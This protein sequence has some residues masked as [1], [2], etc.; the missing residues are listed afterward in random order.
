LVENVGTSL[1]P[2]LEPILLQ[3]V[4][5]I[6]GSKTIVLGDKN[7]PYSDSFKFFMTTTN[8]NPHYSPEI[9]AKVTIIN[10]GITPLGLEE[11]ML[12]LVVI[13]ESPEVEKKKADIVRTNAADKKK[14]QDIEDVI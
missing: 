11:Q 10:F 9:S 8:P 13:M 1:D 6:G 12:A 7:I 5:K 14:L 3:Q 2:A 4:V